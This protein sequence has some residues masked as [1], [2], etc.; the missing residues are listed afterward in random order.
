MIII[1]SNKFDL[2]T[3]RVLD[4]LEVNNV[5]YLLIYPETRFILIEVKVG[6]FKFQVEGETYT[7]SSLKGM[8]KRSG[9]TAGGCSKMAGLPER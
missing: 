2:T 1:F 9:Q 6:N 7:Y 8:W 3:H 4:G 5:P